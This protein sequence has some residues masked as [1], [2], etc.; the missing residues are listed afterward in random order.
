MI[1]A[2]NVSINRLPKVIVHLVTFLLVVITIGSIYFVLEWLAKSP[3]SQDITI[4]LLTIVQTTIFL[5]VTWLYISYFSPKAITADGLRKLVDTF[6]VE[7]V[8]IGLLYVDY[9]Q[10]HQKPIEKATHMD[11]QVTH[12]TGTPR[13]DYKLRHKVSGREINFYVVMSIKKYEVVYYIDESVKEYIFDLTKS[14]AV[15][16]GYDKTVDF[17]ST[18]NDKGFERHSKMVFRRMLNDGFLTDPEERLFVANDISVMTRSI[19]NEIAKCG[20]T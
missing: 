16:S 9:E 2:D 8:R 5:F 3:D 18:C 20:L 13:A 12:V 11:I 19:C 14:G 7:D 10:V 1:N 6:L 17:K 4:T 15:Q